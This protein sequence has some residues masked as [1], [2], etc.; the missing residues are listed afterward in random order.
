M[1]P[2]ILPESVFTAGQIKEFEIE[3]RDQSGDVDAHDVNASLE[4]N[5]YNFTVEKVG[6]LKFRVTHASGGEGTTDNIL[7]RASETNEVVA[8]IP[9]RVDDPSYASITYVETVV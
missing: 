8:K 1:P 2:H 5:A 4:I 3:V 9:V 6:P 7:I